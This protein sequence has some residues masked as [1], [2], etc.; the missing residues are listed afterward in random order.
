[1]GRV[2]DLTEDDLEELT[3]EE[4]EIL[5]AQGLIEKREN[6]EDKPKVKNEIRTK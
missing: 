3:D 4:L 2:I 5:E 1:M 6:K